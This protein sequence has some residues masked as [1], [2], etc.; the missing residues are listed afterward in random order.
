MDMKLCGICFKL[1]GGPD[2]LDYVQSNTAIPV[3][4]MGQVMEQMASVTPEEL[5]FAKKLDS[6]WKKA[7]V[8]K[9]PL[10]MTV[11][12]DGGYDI[13]CTVPDEL[14]AAARL[15]TG[16]ENEKIIEEYA[17]AH[18]KDV[19]GIDADILSVDSVKE[20][21]PAVAKV[22]PVPMQ[23]RQGF[24]ISDLGAEPEAEVPV[25][26]DVSEFAGMDMDIP[27][28]AMQ[29]APVSEPAAEPVMEAEPEAEPEEVSGFE[30]YEEEPEF[31]DDN[32]FGEEG[33]ALEEGY[34]EGE[35]AYGEDEGYQEE[36]IPADEEAVD[37]ESV[38]N[39]AM[40][41]IYRELV[42]NIKDRKLDER[43]GL[44]IGQ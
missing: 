1:R 23:A 3:D 2:L 8:E 21:E 35:E 39:D 5:A 31:A 36:D 14:M 43:L 19:C 32:A 27:I 40:S 10:T 17:A 38:M 6:D 34:P 18:L 44:K 22:A 4:V 42:G 26:E 13:T 16:F 7:F 15:V 30:E 24:D 41:G 28:P 33:I 25:F 12:E 29:E 11:T 20:N 9:V 37:E